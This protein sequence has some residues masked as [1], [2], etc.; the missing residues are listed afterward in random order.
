MTSELELVPLKQLEP[1][2]A[3]KFLDSLDELG[4]QVKLKGKC[5]LVVAM[6]CEGPLDIGIRK[7]KD[8]FVLAIVI[9]L[10]VLVILV[11]ALLATS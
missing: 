4:V 3:K 8:P 10:A 11:S 6:S 7:R 1:A 2:E 9:L 5:S